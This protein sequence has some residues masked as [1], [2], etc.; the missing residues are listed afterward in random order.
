MKRE[1]IIPTL[2]KYK[3]HPKI[4]DTVAN[5]YK[6]D[7]RMIK[8]GDIEL[9]VDITSGIRQGCTGSRILFELIT[10]IIIEQIE[11][12]GKGFGNEGVNIGALFYADDGLVLSHTVEEA[13]RNLEI[14]LDVS[15][16]FG[17]E[18]NK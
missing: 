3:I 4:I 5:V 7:R 11:C 1:Q 9:E 10:Y 12:T 6:Q 15:K 2:M 16:E 14:L 18:I 13:E 17:L 8:I